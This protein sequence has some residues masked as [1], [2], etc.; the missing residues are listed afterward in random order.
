MSAYEHREKRELPPLIE[1]L[2]QHGWSVMLYDGNCVLCSSSVEFIA[3]RSSRSLLAF[4]AMQSDAGRDALVRLGKPLHNYETVVVLEQGKVLERSDATLRLF[5][6]MLPLWPGI[7]RRLRVLPG[8]IRDALYRVLAKYRFV[9]LGR[10]ERCLLLV[11]SE[12]R[13]FIS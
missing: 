5:E 7:A 10:R 11:D 12:H 6:H 1:R 9:I 4:C 13:R 2:L 3:K 8:V